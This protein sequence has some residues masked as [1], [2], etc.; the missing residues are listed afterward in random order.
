MQSASTILSR[1]TPLPRA[2]LPAERYR[3]RP[4]QHRVGPGEVWVG[5]ANEG[6]ISTVLGSCVSLVLWQPMQKLGA[7]CHFMLPADR[8][9]PLNQASGRYAGEA[10][11]LVLWGLR[12]R[13]K[14]P[15]ST[16]CT[17][18]F[19]GADMYRRANTF[20]KSVGEQNVAKAYELVQAHGL[21]L[22]QVDVR[23]ET[24][25]IVYL[26]TVHGTV[27]CERMPRIR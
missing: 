25:R 5:G 22:T 9:V 8:D 13:T 27:S 10:V 17:Y 1:A 7:L 23:D 3:S 24:P 26:D 21:T 15:W 16:F 14:A 6:T 18:L 4:V 11:E 12:Q 20:G 19:G 2:P